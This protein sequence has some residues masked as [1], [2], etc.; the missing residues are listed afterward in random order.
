M[1]I[2]R[3]GLEMKEGFMKFTRLASMCLLMTLVSLATAQEIHNWRSSVTGWVW[4]DGSG[5][6]WRDGSWTPATAAPDC[7]GAI[8]AKA[9]TVA[10][11][12]VPASVP[13]PT[14]VTVAAPLSSVEPATAQVVPAALQAKPNEAAAAESQHVP[15]VDSSGLV[16]KAVPAAVPAP[17][18][19]VAPAPAP[20]SVVVTTKMSFA[21]GTLFDFDKSVLKPAG[22]AQ[23]KELVEK[24]KNINLE[25]VV[26]VGHTDSVGTDAYNQKLSERR[27]E[28]VKAYLVSLGVAKNRI[29]TEGKGESTPIA[30]N[31][32]AAGRAKNRRVEVEVIGSK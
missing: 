10:P 5:Q 2:C 32:T 20:A 13:V 23:L 31:K 9:V 19:L 27:A 30:D 28:S 3:T 21:A 15:V 25:V 17:A 29:Y 18:A 4:R 12:P 7:D 16:A 6:C 8:T 22:K 1:R 24:I 26:V 11:A 14:P